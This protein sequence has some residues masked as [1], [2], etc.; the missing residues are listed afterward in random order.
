MKKSS[1]NYE[2]N[3]SMSY[4]N[5]RRSSRKII[6]KVEGANEYQVLFIERSSYRCS[7]LRARE[8]ILYYMRFVYSF[9]TGSHEEGKFRVD[10]KKS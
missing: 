2:Y 4:L 5:S 10:T 8:L 3:I 7:K 6:M 9:C 1:E